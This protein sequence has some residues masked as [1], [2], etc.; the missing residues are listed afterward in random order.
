MNL[1]GNSCSVEP[2]NGLKVIQ[3]DTVLLTKAAFV[4]EQWDFFFHKNTNVNVN[5]VVME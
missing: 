2:D 4:L 3:N 5:N 1:H